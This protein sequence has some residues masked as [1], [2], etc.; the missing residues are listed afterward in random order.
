M[1]PEQEGRMSESQDME[2]IGE[3]VG[4][5]LGRYVVIYNVLFGFSFRKII[6]IPGL[7]KPIDFPGYTAELIVLADELVEVGN[8]FDNPLQSVSGPRPDDQL[9]N[10]LRDY[11]VE[12]TNTVVLLQT[13][14]EQLSLKTQNPFAYSWQAYKAN[15]EEYRASIE[16]YKVL[17]HQLNESFAA[18]P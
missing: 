7:F 9:R 17:G 2:S 12:L 15:L 3:Y 16:R 1:L 10:A 14:C 4:E 13:L 6:P 11:A 5:L 8:G 18:A